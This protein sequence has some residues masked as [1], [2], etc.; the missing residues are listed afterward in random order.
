[1]INKNKKLVTK[2]GYYYKASLVIALLMSFSV[3]LVGQSDTSWY[4]HY[5]MD[6]LETMFPTGS[7]PCENDAVLVIN[8]SGYFND[9]P[10][11]RSALVR[12]DG[13]NGDI[14]WQTKIQH[15]PFA[16]SSGIFFLTKGLI[17][18]LDGT[19]IVLFDTQ[20]EN[21]NIGFVVQRIAADGSILWHK[22]YGIS[23][24][25]IWPIADGLG[26][27]PDSMSFVVIAERTD[28]ENPY[29]SICFYHINEEG[30]VL[31]QLKLSTGLDFYS[32]YCPVV[33]LEDSSF[34]VGFNLGTFNFEANKLLRQFSYTGQTLKTIIA[35][36]F[37]FWTDLKRHPSGNIVAVSQSFSGEWQNSEIHGLRTT[38][39]SPH[40]DT[41]WSRV[42]NHFELPY[43]YREEDYP[44]PVSFDPK[45]NI[46]VSGS[47][48][49]YNG[50]KPAHL[51]KYNIDGEV[52]WVK[53]IGIGPDLGGGVQEVGGKIV[54]MPR[55][56]LLVGSMLDVNDMLLI[57][58]DSAGCINETT[59]DTDFLLG[60]RNEPQKDFLVFKLSPN[61]TK[62]SVEFSI[63]E[64]YFH[65]LI[66]PKIDLFDM[67]GRILS[68]FSI[69]ESQ[70]QLNISSLP[71][72]V[73]LGI[74]ESQGRPV[75]FQK[76]I[77]W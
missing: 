43:Y 19:F 27:G 12:V 6:S 74:L 16:E 18:L 47:G 46:L 20:T 59:C 53:R 28:L 17:R 65:T 50:V 63:S 35:W 34:V 51:I 14:L 21:G 1:M 39:Y 4:R 36:D 7:E 42:Y 75:S 55:G 29:D 76:L 67:T 32:D 37:G 26:I 72:G 31:N 68:S 77:K 24:E 9:P 33:M 5:V 73:Y 11:N 56:I 44:G 2:S 49:A 13:E 66:K 40:L 52:L 71:S 22:D 30:D 38:L 23:G 62:Y 54:F 45:G 58:L 3:F 25:D 69:D 64:D 57:R 70:Q 8:A 41:L 15:N 48:S 10:Y 61:P 60:L